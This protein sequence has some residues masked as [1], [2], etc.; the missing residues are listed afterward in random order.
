M[1]GKTDQLLPNI[2]FCNHNKFKNPVHCVFGVSDNHWVSKKTM[3]GQVVAIELYIIKM[4]ALKGWPE[5]SKILILWDFT[6]LPILL[7]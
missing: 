4:C 2:N 7:R 3:Q 6:F 5:D 1:K